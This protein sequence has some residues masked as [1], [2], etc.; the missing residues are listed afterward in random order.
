ME[1][2]QGISLC[3][4]LYLKQAKM[5]FFSFTKLQNWRIECRRGSAA[6]W[7]GS[8]LVSMGGRRWPGKG[9]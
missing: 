7:E 5:S 3:S 8:R 2:S 9:G 6:G 1:I 4:Y